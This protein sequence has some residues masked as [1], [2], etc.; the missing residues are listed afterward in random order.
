MGWYYSKI[1]KDAET[2]PETK[3]HQ[4]NFFHHVVVE[5]AC[6]HDVHAVMPAVE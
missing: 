2:D 4:L 1:R 5:S 3:A 6:E